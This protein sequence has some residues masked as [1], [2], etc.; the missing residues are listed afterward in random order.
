VLRVVQP[1]TFLRL[2]RQG[3]RLF[4]RWKSR[5]GRPPISAALQA[6]IRQMARENPIWGQER[7]A[8]ELL[9]KPGLQ[10]S[11]RT[12]RKYLPR[13]LD[14]GGSHRTSSQC[15][16]TLGRNHAKVIVACDFC[17]VVT[18]AFPLLSVF[19]VMEHAT[20]RIL[21]VNVTAHP[22][23]LWTLQQLRDVIPSNHGYCFLIDQCIGHL[24]LRVPKNPPRSPQAN[25]LCER[26]VGMLWRECLDF[27][28]PLTKKHLRRILH[29]WVL[30]Y[31]E[32]GPRMALG[33][34]IP[35][36]PPQLPC[37]GERIGIGFQR[38]YE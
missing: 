7:I 16:R 18:A 26:L 37:R 19:V 2:H 38:I 29:A 17:T 5:H 3:F 21:H 22:T 15:W 23:A 8:N 1:G 24:G 14:R 6:L 12:V 11:P 27:V 9:L 10:M 30:H 36:P 33:P 34:G 20:R 32:G 28:I 13:R 4:W 31:N 25:V 35:Q